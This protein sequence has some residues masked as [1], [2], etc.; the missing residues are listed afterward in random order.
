ME[1]YALKNEPE[2]KAHEIKRARVAV[3]QRYYGGN[4]DEGWT[5]FLLE[6]FAFPYTTIRDEEI[7]RGSLNKGYD[8]IILPNDT[9]RLII[10]ETGGGTLEP[11]SPSW[12]F[13]PEYRSGIGEQ[14]VESIKEF[15]KAGGT[16][17]TFNQACQFAIEKMGLHVRNVL[18]NLEPT[19]WFCPG[20]TLM[21][22][23]DNSHTLAYGMPE[24][25]LVLS[26]ES[27]AFNVIPSESNEDY[28]IVVKYPKSEILRSGWL[29]GEERIAEKAAMVSA[30]YGKGKVIL[31]GFMA[32]ERARTHGTFKLLF[33]A[34]LQ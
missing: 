8:T 34:L 10:G 13:P 31:I 11:W 29:I 2:V 12:K 19:E 24:E 30:R 15:V 14:G 16:L 5:R 28:E 27:P 18:K 33:N 21:T 32:Q 25:A 17:V 22:R 9:V 1:F 4:A 7:A 26:W 20:S 3:Y 23:V 6:G